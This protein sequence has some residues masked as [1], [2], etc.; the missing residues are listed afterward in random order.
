MSLWL[1]GLVLT[2]DGVSLCCEQ[3]EGVG[4]E[5][6]ER[7]SN[8][9]RNM[10]EFRKE[11]GKEMVWGPEN[12]PAQFSLDEHHLRPSCHHQALEPPGPQS[13]LLL[14]RDKQLKTHEK[15]KCYFNLN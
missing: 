8:S 2:V 7:T 11:R 14:H 10:R 6:W 13:V 9:G 3:T 4:R 1:T 12:K 15:A 5:S